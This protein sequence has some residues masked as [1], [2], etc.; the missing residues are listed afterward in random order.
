MSDNNKT[1][2]WAPKEAS[3]VNITDINLSKHDMWARDETLIGLANSALVSN[4]YLK[5]ITDK[6]GATASIPEQTVN[7]HKRSNKLSQDIVKE[8]KVTQKGLGSISTGLNVGLQSVQ[9]TL[10]TGFH[11]I[12]R[13]ISSASAEALVLEMAHM[14]TS[15]ISG[16]LG[17]L[18]KLPFMK[19]LKELGPIVEAAGAGLAFIGTETILTTESF[20][21]LAQSGH[22]FGGSMTDVIKQ[23]EAL[24]ISFSDLA[25]YVTTYSDSSAAIGDKNIAKTILMGKSIDK[26]ISFY[27]NFNMNATDYQNAFGSFME[28]LNN[29]GDLMTES[30]GNLNPAVTQYLTNL[31]KLSVITGQSVKEQEQQQQAWAQEYETKVLEKRLS[32]KQMAMM[33]SVTSNL[34]PWEKDLVTRLT[35]ARLNGIADPHDVLTE[36]LLG[37]APQIGKISSIIRTGQDT[38]QNLAALTAQ[39]NDVVTKVGKFVNNSSA[40]NLASLGVLYGG[41]LDGNPIVQ[42]YKEAMSGPANELAPGYNANAAFKKAQVTP[43][44]ETKNAENVVNQTVGAL[45]QIQDSIQLTATTLGVKILP[46]FTSDIEK[47]GDIVSKVLNGLSNAIEHPG[48]AK[49]ILGVLEH[50][51]ILSAIGGLLGLHAGASLLKLPGKIIKG[52]IHYGEKGLGMM[53]RAVRGGGKSLLRIAGLGGGDAAA[54]EAAGEAAA[55][56]GGAAEGAG[57]VLGALI[58]PEV[59]IPAAIAAAV[60]LGGYEVWKHF[61]EKKKKPEQPKHAEPTHMLKNHPTNNQVVTKHA[62]I[63]PLKKDSKEEDKTKADVKKTAVIPD[64][65]SPDNI[66]KSINNASSQEVE[67][68]KKI[69][70]QLQK[71]TGITG[72]QMPKIAKNIN[73]LN[74]NF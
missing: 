43:N 12:N 74:P 26:M 72:D 20:M 64:D 62:S 68:L 33:T 70:N 39:S 32:P 44:N 65:N 29:T 35:I 18:S 59:L 67:L 10:K 6:M 34:P 47:L 22:T 51:P 55:V 5:A 17:G 66:V 11:S 73:H 41:A 71:L 9:K 56:S 21:K 36:Q 28:Q 25:D 19:G 37:I 58:A 23:A 40:N 13:S 42:T 1:S 24:K 27:S 50:H 57:G 4:S 61:I 30:F 69:H 7:H 15:M 46:K 52:G 16:A 54:G 63:T 3:A 38:R 31:T 53:W 45:K 8:T 49:G 2:I 48:H 14:G 60:G